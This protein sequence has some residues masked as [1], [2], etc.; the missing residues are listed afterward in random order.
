MTHLTTGAIADNYI[1]LCQN[2]LVD[3]QRWF[4][5]QSNSVADHSAPSTGR[6]SDQV[7]P[8]SLATAGF[9]HHALHELQGRMDAH[10]DVGK[11]THGLPSQSRTSSI[12]DDGLRQVRAEGEGSGSAPVE[13]HGCLEGLE[14][15]LAAINGQFQTTLAAA[16]KSSAS[17][18][19]I[20]AIRNER[21]IAVRAARERWQK[22]IRARTDRRLLSRSLQKQSL[23]ILSLRRTLE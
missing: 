7:P 8:A 6:M 10:G 4:Q 5:E 14:S 22:K 19:V 15:E 11:N 17:V 16:R 2:P 12:G 18:A 3:L 9:R 13:E 23:P 21:I 20:R 1:K